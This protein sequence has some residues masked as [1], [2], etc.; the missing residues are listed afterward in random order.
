MT[1]VKRGTIS[2]KRRKNILKQVKGY[3]FGRST[4]ERQANEA[5]RHAG[6]HAF[7]DRRK[8]KNNFRRLW[9]VQISA[10]VKPFETSYSKFIHALKE[11]KIGLNR[12]MLADMA[13][14][15]KETFEKIVEKVK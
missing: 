9:Q 1:R 2:L 15:N 3:R 7:G 12:K 10:A 8:K 6:N 14:N 5:I 4:K 11:K 13:E